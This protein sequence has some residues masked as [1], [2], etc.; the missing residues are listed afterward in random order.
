MNSWGAKKWRMT[1][2][3]VKFW[4]SRMA[5][6]RSCLASKLSKHAKWPNICHAKMIKQQCLGLC[7]SWT[8]MSLMQYLGSN[9]KVKLTSTDFRRINAWNTSTLSTF[10]ENRNK[11]CVMLACWYWHY[12]CISCLCCMKINRYQLKLAIASFALH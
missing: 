9:S 2:R 10:K 5:S 12:V 1:K 6:F 3:L 8:N 7:L 4:D 11:F